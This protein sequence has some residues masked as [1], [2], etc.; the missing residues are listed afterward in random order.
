MGSSFSSFFIGKKSILGYVLLPSD[1]LEI[2]DQNK[3]H[4][5]VSF[6]EKTYVGVPCGEMVNSGEA[7]LTEE[8]K[9]LS[10]FVFLQTRFQMPLQNLAHEPTMCRG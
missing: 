4:Y 3:M 7:K 2:K 10:K 9:H 8:R 5:F 6:G 1:I